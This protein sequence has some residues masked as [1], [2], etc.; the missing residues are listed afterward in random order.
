MDV[1]RP[2]PN[3]RTQRQRSRHHGLSGARGRRRLGGHRR[4]HQLRRTDRNHVGRHPPTRAPGHAGAGPT[5]RLTPRP[6]HQERHG[7]E[8]GATEGRLVQRHHRVRSRPP[9]RQS[10]RAGVDRGCLRA[11]RGRRARPPPRHPRQRD[12]LG[13]QAHRAALVD[14]P[15][16]RPARRCADGLC[17][18]RRPGAP[19]PTR[20]RGGPHGSWVRQA[21][22]H[23]PL[24]PGHRAPPRQPSQQPQARR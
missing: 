14:P 6:A 23:R 13:S 19:R 11:P 17:G 1:W 4:L 2:P 24:P 12:R 8:P 3:R 20:V 5:G 16:A 7:S 21:R 18:H 9:D 15:H 22:R 10:R